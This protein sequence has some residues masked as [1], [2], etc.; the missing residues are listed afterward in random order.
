VSIEEQV[1]GLEITIYDVHGM[2]IVE[3]QYNFGGVEFGHGIGK[4]LWSGQY[5]TFPIPRRMG[6][7]NVPETSVGG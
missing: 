3:S 1:L 2:Q 6:R 7:D 4:T 5:G